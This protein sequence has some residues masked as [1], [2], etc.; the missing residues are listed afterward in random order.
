M[1]DQIPLRTTKTYYNEGIFPYASRFKKAR[2]DTDLPA[3]VSNY[4]RCC[5]LVFWKITD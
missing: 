5:Q 1:K 3:K 2:W 4:T